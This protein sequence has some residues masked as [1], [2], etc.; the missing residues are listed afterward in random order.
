[1]FFALTGTFLPYWTLYLKSLQFN[2]KD[3]GLLMGLVSSTRIVAPSLWGYWADKTGQRLRIVRLGSWLSFIAFLCVFGAHS[4]WSLVVVLMAYAFF[5]NAIL[6]QFEAVTM[7][8]LGAHTERYGRIRL[9]GSLGFVLMTLGVGR[10]LEVESVQ[11]LPDVL[12]ILAFFIFVSSL[13]VPDVKT[14]RRE[15]G[16]SFWQLLCSVEVLVFFAS[17]FLNQLA[18]GP[19]YTFYSIYLQQYGY[20]AWIIGW[21]WGLGVVAEILLF[22]WVPRWLMRVGIRRLLLISLC[23]GALRWLLIGFFPTHFF[24]L[25]LAQCLH[26]ASFG[27]FHAAGIA[28]VYQRFGQGHQGQGQALF[29]AT[30]FGLGGALGA[31]LAGQT[32]SAWGPLA[33]FTIASLE[34]LVAAWL[35]LR[36]SL[37]SKAA[38]SASDFS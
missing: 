12:A 7:A 2:A 4:Y 33:S 15:E 3:I 24:L 32:W 21:M 35:L 31:L 19:Y 8:H 26:A 30:G 23:L 20:S 11:V 36:F 27:G 18:H 17:N 25:M 10:I 1:M 22:A 9:W 6:A 14:A 29:S 38:S 37:P 34:C 16:Q 28:Y 13:M 5:Q